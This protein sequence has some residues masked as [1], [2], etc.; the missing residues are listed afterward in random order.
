MHKSLI[1]V[2]AI[3]ATLPAFAAERLAEFSVP[4]MNCAS[5][6]FIV[7]AAMGKVEGV[8]EVKTD[9][10]AR[11]ASVRFDD[12]LTTAAIIAKASADAGYAATLSEEEA[13]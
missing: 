9:I 8:L 11:T 1:T 5:C 6:P 3:F 4:G 12:A 7:E 10:E 2:A 13:R